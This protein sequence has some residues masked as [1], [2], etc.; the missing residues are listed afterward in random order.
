MLGSLAAIPIREEPLSGGLVFDKL[1]K[2]LYE[3]YNVE[4]LVCATPIAPTRSLRVSCQLYNH[5]S[6]YELLAEILRE[7]ERE[8]DI[9]FGLGHK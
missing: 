8:H 9:K 6:D 5:K 2:I 3:T 1:Q 4:V 7:I